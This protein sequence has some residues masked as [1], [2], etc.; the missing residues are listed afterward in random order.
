MAAGSPRRMARS[1]SLAWCFSCSRLGRTGKMPGGKALGCSLTSAHDGPPFKS[2]PCP[3][4]RAKRRF[5]TNPVFE[6][7]QV[8]SSPLRG[9]VAS[10]APWRSIQHVG[11]RFR[12]AHRARPS[13]GSMVPYTWPKPIGML[14]RGKSLGEN[15]SE[16]GFVQTCAGRETA[17]NPFQFLDAGQSATTGPLSRFHYDARISMGQNLE[18]VGP[19]ISL[20]PWYAPKHAQGLESP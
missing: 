18:G 7:R 2:R 11:G 20:E 1:K 17:H 19:L 6:S 13:T 16:S 5:V 12:Q 10:C 9:G 4:H 14:E 8:D 15:R 3:P